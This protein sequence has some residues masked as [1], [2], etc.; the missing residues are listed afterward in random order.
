VFVGDATPTYTYKL[1]SG[2]AS[3]SVVS[4]PAGLTGLVCTSSYSSSSLVADSPLAITCS[5]AVADGYTFDYTAGA[6]TINPLV[7][8]FVVAD[9]KSVNFGDAAPSYTYTIHTGSPSGPTVGDPAGL[10][11]LTCTSS[12]TSSTPASASPVSISCTGAAAHGYTFSYSPAAVTIGSASQTITF[13]E[14]RNRRL[15]DD[16]ISV[17]V[18]S[19]SGLRVSLSSLTPSK[20]S[21]SG[22]KIRMLRVGTCSVQA[23]QSGNNNYAAANPVT[24]SFQI[25]AKRSR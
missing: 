20:C 22:A 16:K 19:S 10:T 21:V 6:V 25:L 23:T 9:P 7:E 12:Y 17:S 11:G 15:E 1:H 8:L 13:D 14:L 4:D 5:G 24:R 2:S 3:G 18:R